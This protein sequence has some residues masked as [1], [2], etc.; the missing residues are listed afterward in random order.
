MKV[1]NDAELCPIAR[2]LQC[3]GDSWTLLILRD[4]FQGTTRFDE[5]QRDLGIASSMLTRR[6]DRMVADGLLE[7]SR[8]QDRPLRFDYRLTDA[9]WDMLPV[10]LAIYRWG[11]SHLPIEAHGLSLV[12]RRTG[13]P[14]SPAV[15][16][17]VSGAALTPQV[18]ELVPGPDASPAIQRRA[19]RLRA[20]RQAT[21][22]ISADTAEASPVADPCADRRST[23][24][25]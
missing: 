20:A 22:S 16:D 23:N 3:V 18:L 19:D 5:F 17:D 12:D 14:I 4:A 1:S 8:Y 9:G 7:K 21:P 6:L 25:R 24:D 15:Y 2:A 13:K 11:E 10:I